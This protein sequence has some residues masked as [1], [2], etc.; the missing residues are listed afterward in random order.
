MEFFKQVTACVNVDG[1]STTAQALCLPFH[2]IE[3]DTVVLAGSEEG[4]TIERFRADLSI[5]G[6]QF[7]GRTKGVD[8]VDVYAFDDTGLGRVFGRDK[9]G[10]LSTLSALEAE[11]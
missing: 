9:D 6:E 7:V 5:A 8:P 11:A 10:L 1:C 4:L 3:V 2:F